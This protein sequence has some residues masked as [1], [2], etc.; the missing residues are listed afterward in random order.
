MKAKI[1]EKI[2]YK[3]FFLAV[4]LVP[5]FLIVYGF[6]NVYLPSTIFLLGGT[7]LSLTITWLALSFLC[8]DKMKEEG[9]FSF[10]DGLYFLFGMFVVS[11]MS[12]L[13]VL[14][15]SRIV[16][17]E[18]IVVREGVIVPLPD[19]GGKNYCM[20][21][22]KCEILESFSGCISQG[23]QVRKNGIISSASLYFNAK[24][25]KDSLFELYSVNNGKVEIDYDDV[26]IV[27]NEVAKTY[28]DS[29]TEEELFEKVRTFPEQMCLMAHKLWKVK[30]CPFEISSTNEDF[31]EVRFSK[32]I[33][34][35]E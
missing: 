16:T 30:K 14:I 35:S 18:N 2:G 11:C 3:V 33:P 29:I 22:N 21:C 32:M 12:Y 8:G 6:Y 15:M 1:T 5:L 28:L 17:H 31:W 25:K 23:F 26:K 13:P 34:I 4:I 24:I 7:F 10:P 9:Y 27:A 19:G 20:F